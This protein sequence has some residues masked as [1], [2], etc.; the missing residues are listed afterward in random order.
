[1]ELDRDIK[2]Y[3]SEGIDSYLELVKKMIELRTSFSHLFKKEK[4]EKG[5][6]LLDGEDFLE[7]AYQI[8]V[9]EIDNMRILKK[10][11]TEGLVDLDDFVEVELENLDRNES[12]I[13]IYKISGRYFDGSENDAEKQGE[14]SINSDIAREIYSKPEGFSSFVYV[15]GEKKHLSVLRIGKNKE[16]LIVNGKAKEK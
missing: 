9:S 5:E 11:N 15:D 16:E 8:L 10:H 7:S 2:Y 4:N 6:N 13:S 12:E 14:I 3:S 1:M